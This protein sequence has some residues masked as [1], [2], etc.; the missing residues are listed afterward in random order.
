MPTLSLLESAEEVLKMNRRPMSFKEINSE[1][2]RLGLWRNVGNPN[3]NGLFRS[4]L[5]AECTDDI[6]ETF[7]VVSDGVYGLRV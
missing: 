2:E 4:A 1:S 3:P 7:F 5:A 6:S